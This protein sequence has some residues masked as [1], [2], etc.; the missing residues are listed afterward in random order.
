MTV[1]RFPFVV[2]MLGL[3]GLSGCAVWPLSSTSA[4]YQLDEGTF[5]EA[6]VPR[7]GMPVLLESVEIAEYLRG[8]VLLQRQADGTLLPANH[9]RWAGS[10]ASN[11]S[12]QLRRQLST[13]LKSQNLLSRPAPA[14]FKPDAQVA[15][16]IVRLDSGPS[17]P[18]VLEARWRLLGADGRLQGNHLV[19]L[20]EEH[21][22]STADQVRAQSL[23]LQQLVVQMA[24]AIKPL[25]GQAKAMAAPPKSAAAAPRRREVEA[26]PSMPLPIRTD[27]EVF[28]F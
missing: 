7:E 19:R 20:K 25:A 23:L 17:Q 4:L 2:A 11:V 27:V 21:Q 10:F 18:A 13:Q 14:G 3:L 15:V 8:D 12:E 28:R 24:D 9:A 1:V 6:P 5:V 16:E 26:R 22:G